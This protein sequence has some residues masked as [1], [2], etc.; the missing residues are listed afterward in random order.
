[1]EPVTQ[2]SG[3]WTERAPYGK[4]GPSLGPVQFIRTLRPATDSFL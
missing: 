3:Q 1:M 2:V 4:P